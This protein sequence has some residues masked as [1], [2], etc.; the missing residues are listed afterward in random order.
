MFES[1]LSAQEL[2]EGTRRL[3]PLSAAIVGHLAIVSAIV[4]VTA[5]IVPPVVPP[6]PQEP[7]L[8]TTVLRPPDLGLP[9]AAPRQPRKGTGNRR[10]SPP[11][12]S[13]PEPLPQ[14]PP[15]ETPLALP[16][17]GDTPAPDGPGGSDEGATGPTGGAGSGL[18]ENPGGGDGGPGGGE[19]G[20]VV[21]RAD[22]VA[23]ELL[24]KV[25]PHYPEVARITRLSGRVTV[26]AVIGL[27]GSVESAEIFSSTN[28][29]FNDAAQTAVLKWRY[30]PALMSGR[31]VRVYF[32][33]RVEFSVR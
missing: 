29:L 20:P 23:P 8:F 31:P 1:T 28:P 17:P 15:I 30:R 33:V 12:V 25:E 32:T 19:A 21:I 22:M 27:D 2:S 13:Q 11:T 24:V 6:E 7:H 9:S 5:L 4:C 14:V 10:P 3:G 16:T 26:K 18:G